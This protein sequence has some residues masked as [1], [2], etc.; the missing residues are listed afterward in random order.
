MKTTVYY[1]EFASPLGTMLVASDGVAL[2]GAWFVGQR[3]VPVIDAGWQRRRE[4][5]VLERAAAELAEYFGGNR[6]R[7]EL[8]L[9]PRGTP[10]QRDVWTAIASVPFGQTISYR[11]L[12]MRAGRPEGIRAAGA[13]TGR[14]PLSIVI[15]CHRIVGSDGTLTG[16]AGGLDKK[17][18]LLALER[19]EAAAPSARRAA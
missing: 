5:P 9:A 16:Y 18:A 4:L 6:R 14:N 7:F 17:R 8:A 13:A 19:G 3:Y 15:P 12:A 1:D 11:E 2:T 10:F